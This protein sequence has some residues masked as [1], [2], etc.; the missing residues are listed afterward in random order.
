MDSTALEI[1]GLIAGAVTSIGFIPQLI[2]GYRTKRLEDVSYF[3]PI[4][5]A[6]G[7]TLWFIYGFFFK[8]IA[9]MAAN[10]FGVSCC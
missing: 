3:M 6:F 5:L 4:V 1:M 9:I 2:K 8:A 10:A 7:M